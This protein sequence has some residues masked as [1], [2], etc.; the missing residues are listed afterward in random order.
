MTEA[1]HAIWNEQFLNQTL[2]SM[3]EGVFT[4]DMQG[5]IN[6]WNPAMEEI[7]GYSAEEALGQKCNL[8]EFNRCFNQVCPTGYQEC[9]ILTH[10]R[11][12]TKECYLRHKQGYDVPVIKNAR[13]VKDQQGKTIGVVETVTN[14]TELI[15][16]RNK[17]QEASR[18]L[19][20]TYRF[21]NIIGKSPVMQKVFEALTAAAASRST[22]LIQGEAAPER[23]WPPRPSISTATWLKNPLS[24]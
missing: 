9:G 10:E 6:S 8:L 11:G 1:S 12:K 2:E 15:E 23:K 22:V 18:R 17:A 5:R 14:T 19:R 16:V 4:L 3:A 20:E 21:G 7:S 13:V 24:R